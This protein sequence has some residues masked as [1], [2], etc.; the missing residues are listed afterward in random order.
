MQSVVFD[1]KITQK[2]A[3]AAPVATVTGTGSSASRTDFVIVIPS[4]AVA[5][6][7]MDAAPA[8]VVLRPAGEQSGSGAVR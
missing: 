6:P 4:L 1:F 7:A 5:L 2:Q 8:V 3:T